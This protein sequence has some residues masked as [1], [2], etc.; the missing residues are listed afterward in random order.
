MI[1]IYELVDF[2][3]DYNFAVFINTGHETTATTI[4]MACYELTS[5]KNMED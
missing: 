5:H 3:C 2:K 4:G 1:N